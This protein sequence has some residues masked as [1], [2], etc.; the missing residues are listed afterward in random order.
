VGS[1]VC[2]KSCDLFGWNTGWIRRE[3][4][5]GLMGVR[6]GTTGKGIKLQLAN[7]AAQKCS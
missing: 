3:E 6:G 4:R 1:L 5:I 7:E 2:E